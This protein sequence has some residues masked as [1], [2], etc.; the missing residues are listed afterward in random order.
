[1]QPSNAEK[2]LRR[3][4][5]EP[6][7]NAFL[8]IIGS[9]NSIKK[10][11]KIT[12]ASWAASLSYAIRKVAIGVRATVTIDETRRWVWFEEMVKT[13]LQRCIIFEI[14]HVV[15]FTV[16]ERPLSATERAQQRWFK[17]KDHG[18]EG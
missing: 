18:Q 1:L 11:R 17:G 3:K 14:D 4:L 12:G 16:D 6:D 5:S 8:T 9:S 10:S 7:T 15:D 13:P 2:L